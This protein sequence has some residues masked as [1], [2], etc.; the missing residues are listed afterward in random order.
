M[1]VDVALGM[2]AGWL[3]IRAVKA[4][5]RITEWGLDPV[6]VERARTGNYP[7]LR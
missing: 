5:R 7:H 2:V 1:V 6:D 3:V 4:L